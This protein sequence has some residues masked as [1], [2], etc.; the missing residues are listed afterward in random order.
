MAMSADAHSGVPFG[1]AVRVWWKIAWLSFGG[2]AGQI[3]LMQRIIVDE[4]RWLDDARFL[5][6]LN[7]CML[8]PGPEA[9]QL[10]TY[11]GWLLHGVRG[12][13]IAGL[14]FI[15]PGALILLLLSW[16]YVLWSGLGLVAGLLLG[17]KA[18]VLAIVLQALIRIARRNLRGQLR[19]LLALA[20]FAALF[21]LG[22]PFPVVVIGAGVIGFITARWLSTADGSAPLTLP[23]IRPAAGTSATALLCLLLWLATLAFLMHTPGVAPVYMQIASLFSK[24]AVVSFGGAYAVLAYVAQ[25]GVEQHQWLHPGEMIDGLGLAETTPGPLILVTQFVGFL[26]AHRHAGMDSPMLAGVLGALLTTWVTFLPCFV[27]I[28]AG[29]PYVERLRNMP[30]LAAALAAITAAVVG[31]MANLALWMALQTLFGE[32]RGLSIW[33][34]QWQLPLP[35]SVQLDALLLT[36]IAMTLVFRFKLSLGPLLIV[37]SGLGVLVGMGG[38]ELTVR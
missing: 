19:P 23:A 1:A 25:E 28:F 35:S 12:G 30:L 8:L 11:I 34:L 33:G 4:K 31:V 20:A 7:Y 2:P 14:L 32:H 3:A 37:C 26:A 27:W 22:L 6:A 9:Q 21:V 36:I 13:L 38:A 18:A 29:A 24:M 10:A 15:L 17:L 5:H 16:I